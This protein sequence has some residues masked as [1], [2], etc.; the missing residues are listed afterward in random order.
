MINL[1]ASHQA[2]VIAILRKYVPKQKA[3]V[4]GSRANGTT[5]AFADLDLCIMQDRPLSLEILS[6]LHE[7]FSESDLPFRVDI[8]DWATT[9]AEFKEVIMKQA[10]DLI[11]VQGNNKQ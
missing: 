11:E 9:S 4:F 1:T 8:V 2:I 7:A 6:D 3:V 10:V 5:K